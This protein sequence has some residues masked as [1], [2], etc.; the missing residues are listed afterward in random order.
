MSELYL[1]LCIPTNGISKWVLPVLE[2]IYAQQ[3]NKEEFEVVLV[4][5]G[6]GDDLNISR[7]EKFISFDN[8][9]YIRSE[10]KGF[11][12]QTFAFSKCK[13]KLIKFVNHRFLMSNGSIQ[14]LIDFSKKWSKSKPFI[15]FTN[16][17]KG[18]E[19]KYIKS[20]EFFD[21]L[22]L[23][24]SWSGGIAFWNE[25]K[26]FSN[27]LINVTFPHF[28]LFNIKKPLYI[29]NN[30]KI[31]EREIDTSALNKGKYNVFKAFAFEYVLLNLELLKN[32]FITF[33]TF[34]HIKK[35]ISK[36]ISKLYLDI[37]ILKKPCSYSTDCRKDWI[38]VFF[39][40]NFIKLKAFI[41]GFYL[42]LRGKR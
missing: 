27:C 3:A 38:S 29:I 34:K 36:F 33:K 9:I 8:F 35:S 14:F 32:E 6:N 31:F 10:S 22:G 15:Y 17:G 18:H 24:S 11:L 41:F 40:Y 13:G 16:S 37:V 4:D 42:F 21:E 23:S 12:N 39:N 2:S 7:L 5:N 1:S 26:P 20:D 28:A 19:Q 30:D 25:D